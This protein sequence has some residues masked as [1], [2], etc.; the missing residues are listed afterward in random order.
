MTRALPF[1]I[2]AAASLEL[3][4]SLTATAARAEDQCRAAMRERVQACTADCVA[5]ARA[6][7]DPATEAGQ[8][9]LG[10]GLMHVG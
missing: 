4:A 7:V 5:K 10:K 9:D 1:A 2:F 3:I 6:A 8:A